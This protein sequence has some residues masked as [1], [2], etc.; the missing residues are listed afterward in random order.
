MGAE[1]RLTKFSSVLL[2]PARTIPSGD[3]HVDTR[4]GHGTAAGCAAV[5]RQDWR[6]QGI[7]GSGM[8]RVDVKL[9]RN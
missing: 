9:N 1:L 3:R 8:S 5:L 4:D 2:I 6:S 7:D